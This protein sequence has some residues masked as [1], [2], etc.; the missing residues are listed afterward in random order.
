MELNDLRLQPLAFEGYAP[1]K[2]SPTLGIGTD[3]EAAAASMQ[4]LKQSRLDIRSM[5]Q[6]RCLARKIDDVGGV[7]QCRKFLVAALRLDLCMAR[8]RWSGRKERTGN[9]WDERDNQ[10]REPQADPH[11][12][13]RCGWGTS[14]L[15]EWLSLGR[16]RRKRRRVRNPAARIWHPTLNVRRQ[17]T[18]ETFCSPA[19][20]GRSPAR[21]S[22]IAAPSRAAAICDSMVHP[23]VISRGPI[24][25]KRSRSTKRNGARSVNH[26]PASKPLQSAT[27]KF[28]MTCDTCIVRQLR[29]S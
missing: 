3:C 5:R 19:R 14:G 9:E 29:S 25:S 23:K 4:T 22:Q 28:A 17:V 7:Y 16:P 27:A 1:L 6:I 10:E 26:R 21:T 8:Q 20:R 11:Q 2:L 18:P 13:L 15:A 12:R 24:A